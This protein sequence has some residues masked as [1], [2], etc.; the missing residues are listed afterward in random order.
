MALLLQLFLAAEMIKEGKRLIRE[1][2]VHPTKVVEG[3]ESGVR[4]S[5][6]L[7]KKSAKKISLDDIELGS[8]SK[9]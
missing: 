9:N 1:L 5:C 6:D 7:L 8:N 3:I 4:H 2:A